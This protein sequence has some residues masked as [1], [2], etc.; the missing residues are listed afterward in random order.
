MFDVWW[1]SGWTTNVITRI[2]AW[3]VIMYLYCEHMCILGCRRML[4]EDAF[5]F[6]APK[7]YFPF[8]ESQTRGILWSNNQIKVSV[9]YYFP[10][11]I[12]HLA[13]KIS[14]P[15]YLEHF[16]PPL[17]KKINSCQIGMK[18]SDLII[19]TWSI[20]HDFLEKLFLGSEY[21]MDVIFGFLLF[22]DRFT[23]IVCLIMY[24]FKD[25]NYSILNKNTKNHFIVVWI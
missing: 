2:V 24:G 16:H 19:G 21:D 3:F 5:L 23:H 15:V 25:I 22:S 6:V 20:A 8:S 1:L 12:Y 11:I 17:M 10:K 13:C 14:H 4:Q 18:L 7:R 9:P